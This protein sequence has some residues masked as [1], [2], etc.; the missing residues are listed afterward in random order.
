MITFPVSGVETWWWLPFLTAL[1][2]SSITSIG[3]ISGAFILLPFQMSVLGYTDPGVSATNLLFNVVAIPLGVWRLYREKRLVWSLAA[4]N[5]LGTLPG[6][7]LGGFLR[8]RYLPDPRHFKL[9]VALVLAYMVFRLVLDLRN[10]RSNSKVHCAKTCRVENETVSGAATL[11]VFQGEQYHVSLVSLGII[12]AFVGVAGGMY[13]IGGGA[14]I[15]PLL[16]TMYR[17]PV[18]VI[19]GAALVGTFVASLG[20]VGFYTWLGPMINTSQASVTPD[21][22]LG[23]LLGMGGAIGIYTGAR[24]QKFIQPFWIKIILSASMLFIIFKY[25]YAFLHV[26]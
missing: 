14:M 26:Q 20:G 3:G 24:L 2:I 15:A 10:K 13:G 8:I 17:V 5:A 4:A 1:G 12:S 7:F 25:L 6:I 21:W 9:F 18:H 23:L 16:V 22:G 11:F 19:A